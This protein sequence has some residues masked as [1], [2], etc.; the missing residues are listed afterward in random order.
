MAPRILVAGGAGFIGA[1]TTAHLLARGDEVVVLDNLSTG[2]ADAIPA[3]ATLIEASI[4]DRAAVA[5]LLSSFKPDACIDF[6]GLIATGE[7]MEQP[8]RYFATNVGETLVFLDALIAAGVEKF[9]FSSSAA[10]YGEPQFLPIPETHRTAPTSVYGATKLHI[11][12]ALSWMARQ[13]TLQYAALRY[14]NAAG[15]SPQAI[16]RHAVETHLIPLALAAAAGDAPTLR[17]FG[18]DYPT[19]DGTCIR[20]YVHVED[21]ATAHLAALAALDR[22]TKESVV[23]LGSGK[24]FSN[25]EV[26]EGIERVTGL[27]VP[28]VV[29]ARRAGDPAVLVASNELAR[30]VLGWVPVKSALDQLLGDAW[31]AYRVLNHG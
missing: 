10:V 4:G 27:P 8:G 25:K 7:S 22:G 18:D 31:A 23:N 14:F 26:L 24:G 17:L 29:A 6:A 16:E 30:E 21:L 2:H 19:P 3:G 28:V 12:E 5:S 1:A 20:D 13:G 11:E 15:G 9:V